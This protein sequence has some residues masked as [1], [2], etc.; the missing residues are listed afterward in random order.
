MTHGKKTEFWHRFDYIVG[1]VTA[2]KKNYGGWIKR[3]W[4]KEKTVKQ[5]SGIGSII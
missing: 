5:S 4:K 2:E 3:Y 1:V